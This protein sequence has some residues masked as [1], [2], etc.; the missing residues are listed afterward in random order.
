MPLP[1]VKLV[2]VYAKEV[3][4]GLQFATKKELEPKLIE[5]DD[6]NNVHIGAA[7]GDMDPSFPLQATV[8]LPL[9]SAP[10]PV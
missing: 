6:A 9:A 3:A 1:P 7:M 5:V 10:Y 4:A 8:K 2:P